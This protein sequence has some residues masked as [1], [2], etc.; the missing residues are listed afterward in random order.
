MSVSPPEH[1]GY[2]QC[3]DI[4]IITHSVE[5]GED[6]QLVCYVQQYR[7]ANIPEKDWR[8]SIILAKERFQSDNRQGARQKLRFSPHAIK[9]V[10]RCLSTSINKVRQAV[11]FF[12]N[13]LGRA[14][15]TTFARYIAMSHGLLFDSAIPLTAQEESANKQLAESAF[16]RRQHSTTTLSGRES[17]TEI[18]KFTN[19][20]TKQQERDEIMTHLVKTNFYGVNSHDVVSWVGVCAILRRINTTSNEQISDTSVLM[21]TPR[22]V[23]ALIHYLAPPASARSSAAQTCIQTELDEV[24]TVLYTLMSDTLYKQTSS[25]GTASEDTVKRL[26]HLSKEDRVTPVHGKLRPPPTS[27]Q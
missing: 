18:V 21:L 4:D 16:S 11:S 20:R 26:M 10:V 17:W 25:S 5:D 6:M 12:K 7:D 14:N 24:D 27:L 13:T 3:G 23:L 8:K 15:G 22:E 2:F 1:P 9:T 19:P